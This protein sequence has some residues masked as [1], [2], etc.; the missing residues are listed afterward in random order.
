MIV[1]NLK[2]LKNVHFYD[3]DDDYYHEWQTTFEYKGQYFVAD[4]VFANSG[5]WD[6]KVIA[7]MQS[8]EF[9]RLYG[10][11]CEEFHLIDENND[12][13]DEQELIYAA[14]YLMQ[15]GEEEIRYSDCDDSKTY[16]KFQQF[17]NNL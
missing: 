5:A 17:I 13:I 9:E 7:K 15:S 4:H 10:G 12:F 11:N 6:Y 1:D 16:K 14:E 8:E 2:I 3:D